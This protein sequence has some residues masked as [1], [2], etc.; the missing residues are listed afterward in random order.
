MQI[1]LQIYGCCCFCNWN[2]VV[3]VPQALTLFY[4]VIFWYFNLL[5]YIA[6]GVMHYF[7]WLSFSLLY[8]DALHVVLSI[9]YSLVIFFVLVSCLFVLCACDRCC[10]QYINSLVMWYLHR[11]RHGLPTTNG[12][13]DLTTCNSLLSIRLLAGGDKVLLCRV[14]VICCFMWM[15][16]RDRSILCKRGHSQLWY[17]NFHK[18]MAGSV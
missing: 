16:W 14:L 4:L 15:R 8:Y 10:L 5:I 13:T 12:C 6:S 9:L 2:F 7:V 18:Y 11:H 17:G 1:T 3:Q